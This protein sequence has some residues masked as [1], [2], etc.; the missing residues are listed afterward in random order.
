MQT[1]NQKNGALS[2]YDK[3]APMPSAPMKYLPDGS[4]DWGNMW[5]SFCVLARDGGPP[6]RPTPLTS[7]AAPDPHSDGYRFAEAEIMRGITAVSHLE[8]VSGAQLVPPRPGWVCIRCDSPGMARWLSEAMGDENVAAHSDGRALFVPVGEDFT[9][10]GEIKN[11]I[12]AV[13][14]TTHYWNEHLAAEVKQTLAMQDRL[15]QIWLR[16]RRLLR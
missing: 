2:G 10:K 3:R 7:P 9:L 4:V 14:K 6:H 13:A 1:Q 12:T 5:D 8:A 15:H 11:V 16:L